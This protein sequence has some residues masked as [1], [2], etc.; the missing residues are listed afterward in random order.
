MK[1]I[2]ILSKIDLI[3][4][5]YFGE[6][7]LKNIIFDSRKIQ[8][9]D[10]YFSL[11]KC[12][13]NKRYEK[14]AIDK[15]AVVVIGETY[16]D[17]YP[18][19]AV[20]NARQTMASFCAEAY[21]HP[22]KKLSIIG[23][24]GTNGKT[25]TACLIAQFLQACKKRVAVIGTL[26]AD[27]PNGRIET[28]MTTPDT[29]AFFSILS[30]C[31]D[32]E[33][34]YVVIEVSAHAI[35]Y[36]KLF[37]VPFEVG[38]FTNMTQDHLDFFKTMD[39]YAAVKKSWLFS[40][41]VKVAAINTDDALGREIDMDRQGEKI[42]FSVKKLSIRSNKDLFKEEDSVKNMLEE[43]LFDG[44]KPFTLTIDG[45]EYT[46][47]SP[48][49]GR[50][51]AENLLAA[52]SAIYACRLPIQEEIDY[53]PELVGASGRFT[54]AYK[55]EYTII[56]DYA[57]TPD[58]L[59]NVLTAAKKIAR[60]RLVVVFGCGGDRDRKKR[61]LMGKIA[62]DIA[63]VVIVTSDNP[64]IEDPEQIID[65]VF[66]GICKNFAFRY[67]D[68]TEAIRYAISCLGKGDVLLVAGKGAEQY[69]EIG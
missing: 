53:I 19:V 45:K 14:E 60:G 9:G 22:E 2:E 34:E 10:V 30:E 29:P 56:V 16:T 3:N 50:H 46:I 5:S 44:E 39:R 12:P 13:Q 24:T 11:A 59:A 42:S 28:G 40:N 38:V 33:V 25:T 62:V 58:G 43:P 23:I 1:I 32:Q 17:K 64:R 6:D 52:L 27:L 4:N 48:L 20:S 61:P 68:R 63:D 36:D 37:A 54:V 57:H 26:G 51:N 21:G 49:V 7:D 8:A 35:Y 55:G 18:Y 15:G 69:M 66:T 31:V 65:D 67:V 41:A 47:K